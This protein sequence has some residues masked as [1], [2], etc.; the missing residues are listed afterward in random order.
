M[1]I[2]TGKWEDIICKC[3]RHA[4]MYDMMCDCPCHEEEKRKAR[5]KDSV[6]NTPYYGDVKESKRIISNIKSKLRI[7]K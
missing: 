5:K 1:G 3:G 6:Q 4:K 7:R 2:F